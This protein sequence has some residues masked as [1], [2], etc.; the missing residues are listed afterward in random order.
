MHI[1]SDFKAEIVPSLECL[2]IQCSDTV[3]GPSKDGLPN[4]IRCL[5]VGS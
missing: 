1:N 3:E 2:H 5:P 4:L